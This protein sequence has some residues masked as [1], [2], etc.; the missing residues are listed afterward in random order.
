M[1][2]LKSHKGLLKRIR[3]TAKKKVKFPQ[4][5][6]R[7]INSHFTGAQ[8]RKLRGRKK[9]AKGADMRRL[10]GMLHMRLTPSDRVR[11]CATKCCASGECKAAA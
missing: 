11:P 7:H 1:P 6:K 2:K 4:H 8:V 3:I 5:G 9:C 10:E